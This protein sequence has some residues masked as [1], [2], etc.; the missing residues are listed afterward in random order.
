MNTTLFTAQFI[1]RADRFD[2]WYYRG[3][4]KPVNNW[5]DGFSRMSRETNSTERVPRG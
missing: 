2:E 1:G 3:L 4:K 5:S